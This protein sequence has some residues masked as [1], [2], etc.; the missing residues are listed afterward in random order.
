MGPKKIDAT[1]NGRSKTSRSLTRRVQ[2][3][4]ALTVGMATA[5]ATVIL[6]CGTGTVGTGGPA[7]ILDGGGIP[8]PSPLC[9][10]FRT[11]QFISHQGST[12]IGFCRWDV[13]ERTPCPAR[14]GETGGCV[15]ISRIVPELAEYERSTNVPKVCLPNPDRT[16][17]FP[18]LREGGFNECGFGG[19]CHPFVRASGIVRTC[20]PFY[21][22]R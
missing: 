3:Q 11:T 10:M 1:Q 2:P 12:L 5:M 17:D 21:C 4:R 20:V 6:S 14:T 18:C 19:F 8:E 15:S 13:P 22:P 16:I 9:E 7:F